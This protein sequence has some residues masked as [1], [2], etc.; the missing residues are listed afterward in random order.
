MG[1]TPATL[2]MGISMTVLWYALPFSISRDVIVLAVKFF[3]RGIFP[4][5]LKQ[6]YETFKSSSPTPASPIESSTW[7]L[8]LPRQLVYQRD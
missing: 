6:N 2:K 7:F 3:V 8:E 4:K 1:R 5:Y